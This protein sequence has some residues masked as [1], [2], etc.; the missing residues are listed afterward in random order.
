MPDAPRVA[1]TGAS[2]FVARNLRKHLA[3][4]RLLSFSRSKFRPLKNEKAVVTDYSSRKRLASKLGSCEVLVHL[5]GIGA[6]G[7]RRSCTDVNAGLTSAVV[8]A[9]KSAKIRQV[10]F[11]SGLG[12]SP[13]NPA[14]YFISKL[15]AERIIRASGL[16]Y[17][18]FRPSFIVGQGGYLAELLNDQAKG[19]RILIPG[20]G[21][22]TLQ[23]VSIHD[24]VRIIQSSFLN[25]KFL[26][27]TLDLVGPD[28]V[29]FEDFVKLFCRKRPTRVS[30]IPLERCLKSAF[31][32][33]NSAYGMDDLN[34]FY[35]GYVGNFKKLQ[36]AYGAPIKPAKD[37]L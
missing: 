30:K 7:G 36:K 12:V 34:L 37:F 17:T 24:V 9:A 35:G 31:T 1:I 26:K 14:D 2:G 22:Y 11:L 27:K 32:D 23:P 28:A 10:V 3:G 16:D 6:S 8:D 18:I 33:K 4:Y 25:K 19:G 29:T 21:K 13:A 5:V 20:D 15:Q